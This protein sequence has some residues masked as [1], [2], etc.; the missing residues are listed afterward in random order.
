MIY[1]DFEGK[2]LS[3]LGFGAMRL[4]TNEDGSIDQEQTNEMMDYALEHGVNYIDTAF[5]YH[6]SM[7][8]IA[9]GKALAKHPRDS[10]YLATKYPGHNIADS[11]DPA[12]TFETQLKKCGVEYFDFYLLHNVFEYSIKTYEDPRWGIIDYFVEEKKKGRIKHLGFSTHGDVPV[13]REFLERHADEMDF[14]QMQLNYLDWTLQD[15]KGKYDLL[16]EYGIPVWVMEPVHGGGLAALP[17]EERAKLPRSRDEASDASYALRW[18]AGLENV[19]MILSGMSNMEQMVDNCR[20]FEKEDP[21]S[22]EEEEVL[23]DI[24]EALKDSIPCTGCRY[25]VDGCPQGLDIPDLISKFNQIRAGSPVTVQIQ[26]D[27][28]PEEKKASACIGCGK[29][30]MVCPQKIDIPAEMKNL[31]AKMDEFVGWKQMSAERVAEMD[32]QIEEMGK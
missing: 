2:K 19:K 23:M 12:A 24:A 27:M 8:E 20:T 18:V 22:D 3:L 13:I 28:M 15:A 1:R 10:Y 31:T 5:P 21:L 14:C 25:C 7:S 32:A 4:P 6:A 16:T 26:I 9:V 11:Y 30:A 29:C 17:D